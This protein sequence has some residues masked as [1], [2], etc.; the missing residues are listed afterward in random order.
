MHQC[1]CEGELLLFESAFPLSCIN[2]SR[3]SLDNTTVCH[4]FNFPTAS[5]VQ[6]SGM[7]YCSKRF[8]PAYAGDI[9][10]LHRHG[11]QSAT[12]PMHLGVR[13]RTMFC[14]ISSCNR[15]PV[16]DLFLRKRIANSI[17][18][19]Q[20]LINASVHCILSAR[21]IE[22]DTSSCGSPLETRLFRL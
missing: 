15:L 20:G 17:N 14:S 11:R 1:L 16:L 6:L 7:R 9:K 3:V 2:E 13:P 21:V 5:L 19:L 18:N 4:P 22:A 12:D 8:L 10:P